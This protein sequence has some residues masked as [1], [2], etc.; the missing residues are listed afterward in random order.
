MSAFAGKTLQSGKYTLEQCLG[1][2]GFGVT[3]KATHHYLNQ[4]VVIK[5]LNPDRIG[6]PQFAS[7]DQRF[8]DEAQRLARCVHPNIVRVNDFFLEE[9]VPYL[10]MD[11]I[12]GQTLDEVVFPDRPLAE[13]IAIQYIRQIGQALE[14]VHEKGLLHRDVKPQNIMVR[15]GTQDVVLI[16]FGIAREFKPGMT[17]THTQ[18]LSEG[19]APVEQYLSQERRTPA[20]DVYGLAATLYTLLTAQVPIASILRDRQPL[21]PPIEWCPHLS[22]SVN[23]AILEGMAIE[24]RHRPATVADWLKRLP[25]SSATQM[26]KTTLT[27]P[28]P[29]VPSASVPQSRPQSQI[30]VRSTAPT[31]AVAP[32]NRRPVSSSAPSISSSSSQSP[33]SASTSHHPKTIAVPSSPNRKGWWG[34]LLVPIVAIAVVS[35]AG[36]GALWLRSQQIE[37]AESPQPSSTRTPNPPDIQQPD[38][39]EIPEPSDNEAAEPNDDASTRQERPSVSPTPRPSSPSPNRSTPSAPPPQQESPP[40][41]I[42]SRNPSATRSVPGFPPGTPT[43][44]IETLLGTPDQSGQ[45]NQPNTRYAQYNLIPNRVSLRYVY[46][47]SSEQVEQTQAS[48]SQAVDPLVMRVAV[49][50]MVGSSMTEEIEQG[51]IQVQ[52]RQSDRYSFQSG[53]IRGVIERDGSD[54]L[55][56]TVTN[57]NL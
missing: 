44:Q 7:L 45:G 5:T 3:F 25:A 55:R 29:S 38:R 24:A 47:Q 39:D 14:I 37:F 2:G 4:A 51:L 54:R 10:V 8:R 19:Y 40:D 32:Q 31:L 52:K 42:E 28:P 18:L 48:F 1:Q 46:D 57:P 36:L 56:V 26:P 35:M 13:A 12:P 43:R 33:P 30:D 34:F 27:P 23:Q 15:E 11:Y 41:Y 17:Q 49:N 16:D 20:T 53:D 6:D 9:A 22:L 50:G 21:V